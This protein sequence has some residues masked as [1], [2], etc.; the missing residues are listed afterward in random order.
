[1]PDVNE[2]SIF[3]I[4]DAN[5]NRALEGLRVCEDIARFVRDDK[6][7]ARRWKNL[8]H[9]CSDALRLLPRRKV[10]SARK[11][12]KDVGRDST[13]VEF[14]RNT[15]DDVFLLIC[16]GSK[17]HCVYWK[18]ASNWLINQWLRK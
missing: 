7:V 6:I 12:Q 10:L 15:V 16:S 4:I 18:N 3:R 9:E 1:M 5:G 11:V 8:R 17:S 2:V 14:Q 13:V